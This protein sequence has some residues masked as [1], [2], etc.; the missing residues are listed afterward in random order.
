MD[1]VGLAHESGEVVA[2]VRLARGG[3]QGRVAAG[4]DESKR[5]LD[6]LLTVTESARSRWVEDI[7]VVAPNADEKAV[8]DTAN[9]IVAVMDGLQIVA[10]ES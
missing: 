9:A 8:V 2:R 6:G 5:G 1:C 3:A 4:A 7:E 10:H